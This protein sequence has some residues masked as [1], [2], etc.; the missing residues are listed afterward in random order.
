MPEPDGQQRFKE[1]AARAGF[2]CSTR[3][4]RRPALLETCT[5]M[6]PPHSRRTRQPSFGDICPNI[7][8]VNGTEK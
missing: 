1:V 7:S 4:E 6:Q 8:F 3:P 5:W 2:G